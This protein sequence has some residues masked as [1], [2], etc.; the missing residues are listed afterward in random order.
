MLMMLKHSHIV[1]LISVKKLT[2]YQYDGQILTESLSFNADD[3]GRAEFEIF[4]DS[5]KKGIYH[6]LLDLHDEFFSNEN[7]P[8]LSILDQR[9]YGQRKLNQL[10]P[11]TPFRRLRWSQ[12][13][14]TKQ[15]TLLLAGLNNPDIVNFWYELFKDYSLRLGSISTVS[16][17]AHALTRRMKFK[18][19]R[20]VLAHTA[21]DH[22]LRFTYL[23]DGHIS[24]SRISLT[25]EENDTPI[26]ILQRES[27][28]LFN[29]LSSIRS[30]G[31]GER[32][33]L[34]VLTDKMLPLEAIQSVQFNDQIDVE[35]LSLDD[36][37]RLAKIPKKLDHT[38]DLFANLTAM[39]GFRNHYAPL[40]YRRFYM[41][42]R[43]R[44]TL[45][46][47]AFCGIL[48]T[49]GGFFV[50]LG[51]QFEADQ[52]Y[53]QIERN[54]NQTIQNTHN[55]RPKIKDNEA[56]PLDQRAVVQNID[57]LRYNWPSPILALQITHEVLRAAPGLQLENLNWYITAPKNDNE[58][59]DN[60][61][62][63]DAAPPNIIAKEN[64]SQ[65]TPLPLDTPLATTME[66]TFR[67]TRPD[68]PYRMMLNWIEVMT[69]RLEKAGIT[70][71]RVDA[72]VNLANDASFNTD[73]NE[74]LPESASFVMVWQIPPADPMPETDANHAP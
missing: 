27:N 63:N 61:E 7:T 49:L 1:C 15:K 17:L 3:F 34:L 45:W 69:E 47:G 36:V 53:A 35:V 14:S 10:L 50:E 42:L 58:P 21:S 30:L 16:L 18:A 48:L 5:N 46:S 28:R 74:P 6:F 8:N 4:L 12:N 26:G 19:K 68:L 44:Q 65:I 22:A 64:S 13:K 9:S 72:P 52:Q 62:N 29:Y 40:E 38:N 39:S 73:A 2:V 37:A 23:H 31:F 43:I 51:W 70:V 71:K 25:E 55:I 66:A 33:T 57:A 32:L 41:L 54:I 24:L 56:S 59:N 60:E 11:R 67:V 20:L